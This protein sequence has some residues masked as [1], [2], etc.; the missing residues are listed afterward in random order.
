MH[1]E[2]GS[3]KGTGGDGRRCIG[4]GGSGKGTGGDVRRCIGMGGGEWE[5]NGRGWKEVHRD[6]GGSGK[7]TRGNGRRCIGMEGGV[8]RERESMG[9]GA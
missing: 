3:G 9:G 7:G 2:G 5:G 6:G 4:I 1:R 8:G